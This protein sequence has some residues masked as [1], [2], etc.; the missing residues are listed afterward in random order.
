MLLANVTSL[1]LQRW[2]TYPAK[3]RHRHVWLSSS[4]IPNRQ[5]K[6]MCIFILHWYHGIQNV[7][8]TSHSNP[9]RHDRN[10]PEETV[11]ISAP[12]TDGHCNGGAQLGVG[13]EAVAHGG[14]MVLTLGTYLPVVG[15]G[16][17][18][19]GRVQVS[20]YGL[21]PWGNPCY[22]SLH[23][24]SRRYPT[25]EDKKRPVQTKGEVSS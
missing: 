24:S 3:Q 5:T 17:P 4:S 20:I 7:A 11:G 9:G 25:E 6:H 14:T 21:L 10:L 18:S 2:L 16:A 8:C 15:L 1:H 23:L 22:V 13:G 12:S 19:H